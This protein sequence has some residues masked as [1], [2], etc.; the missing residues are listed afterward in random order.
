M[1]LPGPRIRLLTSLQVAF[2]PYRTYHRWRANYGPNFLARAVN[3]DVLCTGDP[4]VIRDL[5]RK[6]DDEVGPFRPEVLA[7]LLGPRSLFTLTRQAHT[8][9][10]KLLMPPFHG[11]RMRA[12]GDA[13]V[14]SA[15]EACARIAPGD[16]L[17]MADTMLQV[18]L[19]VIC[20]A[21]FGVEHDLP[22]WMDLLRGPIEN[23][24]PMALFVPATQQSFV[25]AW[26]RFVVARDA[27]DEAIHRTISDRREQGAQGEDIL[28]LMLNATYEDGSAMDDGAVRDELVSLLFAGHET[29]QISMAW[30]LRLI[31]EDPVLLADLRDEVDACDGSPA[32][33]AKL[34]LL[35]ATVDEALRIDPIVPDVLRTML[36][37][38]DLGGIQVTAGT[39]VSPIAALVHRDPEL[40]PDPEIFRPRRF[41]EQ[42]FR[43]WEYLPFGGGTRRCIGAALATYEMK[44]VLGTVLRRLSLENDGDDWMVRRSVTMGPKRGAPMRCVARRTGSIAP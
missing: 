6:T 35:G 18:S 24:S 36:V 34:P 40:Y 31:H 16:R 12:Y 44:L 21:I 10:R 27:L 39:H 33:L 13:I 1:T 15:E 9:E 42:R 4:A 32:E 20:R 8:R 30:A 2:A 19:A 23:I 25:P 28:S 5:F 43:P 26:R 11:A 29:T 14:C 3:G 41:L 17:R 7:P 38:A 22:R 37:D